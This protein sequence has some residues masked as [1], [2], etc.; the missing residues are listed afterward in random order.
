MM[1]GTPATALFVLGKKQSTCSRVLCIARY[2]HQDHNHFDA[3]VKSRWNQST[4][5]CTAQTTP[6]RECSASSDLRPPRYIP[7]IRMHQ[8]NSLRCPWRWRGWA[9]S[10]KFP[11]SDKNRIKTGQKAKDS[12]VEYVL[13]IWRW[14]KDICRITFGQVSLATAMVLSDK[15]KFPYFFRSVWLYLFT[16]SCPQ[17]CS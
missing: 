15:E 14:G 17:D 9:G 11:K 6:S 13:K 1:T 8:V 7:P 3:I 10:S 2:S 12:L 16:P 4:R 5:T